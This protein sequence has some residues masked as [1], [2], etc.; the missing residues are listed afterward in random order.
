MSGSVE[1]ARPDRPTLIPDPSPIATGE[2]SPKRNVG[3]PQGLWK[4]MS[5][6]QCHVLFVPWQCSVR[7]IVPC[8]CDRLRTEPE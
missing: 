4:T 7:A 1:P 2:G 3:T 5:V 6:P 8:G